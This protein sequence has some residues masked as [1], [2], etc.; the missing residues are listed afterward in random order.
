MSALALL[1]VLLA[2]LCHTSWNLL[3]KW[4]GGGPA[5]LWLVTLVSALVYASVLFAALMGT[6]FLAEANSGRR[7]VA[8]C[9]LVGGVAALAVG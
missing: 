3:L 4:A 5:F 7:I 2:A 6:H 1:L 9:I 8:A